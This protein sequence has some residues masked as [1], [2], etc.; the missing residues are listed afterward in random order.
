MDNFCNSP[1]LAQLEG[2]ETVLE[3]LCANNKNVLPVVNKKL[4][5]GEHCGQHSN[6]CGSSCMETLGSDYDIYIP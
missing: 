1:E 3:L 6:R 2:G 5:K 4:K